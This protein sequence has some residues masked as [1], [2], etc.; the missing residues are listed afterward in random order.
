MYEPSRND[1]V[2]LLYV[3]E[4]INLYLSTFYY[5]YKNKISAL[6]YVYKFG[7]NIIDYIQ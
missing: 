1:L 3:N 7:E 4:N 5:M 6:F 2:F